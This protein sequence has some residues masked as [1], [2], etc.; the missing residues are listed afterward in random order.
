MRNDLHGILYTLG[1]EPAL[2]ELVANRNSAS[3][4]YGARYR[5]IDFALSAMVNAG[6][7]DVGVIMERDYQSLLDHLS[8]GKDWDLSRRRGGL[9]LLPPFGLPESHSGH[10]GGCMEALRSVSSYIR[11]IQQEDIVLAA[12]DWVAN[13]DLA[14][15][16]EIHAASGAGITAVC[17][18]ENPPF[19]H[20]RLVPG[21]DGFAGTLLF[22]HGGAGEELAS[23]EIYILKK[24]LLLELMD[25]C[26]DGRRTHFHRDALAHFLSQG[27][28]MAVYI[29]EGYFSRITCVGDYYR[30]SMDLLRPEVRADLFPWE[31]RPIRTKERAESSTYY[32]DGAKVKNC[33]VADGCYVEGEIQN[34]ILFRGVRVAAGARLENCVIMQDTVVQENAQLK[35]VI[36][37]KDCT[38]TEGCFL[39]GSDR[40]PSVI[41]KGHTV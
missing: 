8:S 11:D 17:T 21:E 12:G 19:A 4:P 28:K 35:S 2:G 20:H 24:E 16:L 15:A 1:S 37:D 5:L 40:L 41:P 31:T 7:R 32:G 10:F 3:I 6:V 27:G 38:V 22:S 14:A 26:S 36:A 30:A 29:H 23:T 25:Y 13:V 9:R 39:A 33:L 18:R 34:C